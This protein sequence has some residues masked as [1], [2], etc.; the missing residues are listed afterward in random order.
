MSYNLFGK[1]NIQEI[2]FFN[3]M[4]DFLS[5]SYS[6]NFKWNYYDEIINYQEQFQYTFSQRYTL[7][8]KYYLDGIKQKFL[9]SN[10]SKIFFLL[11][12]TFSAR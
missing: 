4:N 12:E 5:Q 6:K 11:N 2:I 8:I 7:K 10:K 3:G 1:Y 9:V